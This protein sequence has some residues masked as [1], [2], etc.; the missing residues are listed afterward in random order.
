MII[1]DKCRIGSD[2][3]SIF[4]R[5]VNTLAQ[6]LSVLITSYSSAS[7][8]TLKIFKLVHSSGLSKKSEHLLKDRTHT[9]DLYCSICSCLKN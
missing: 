3:H 9:D 1:Y 4:S 6:I 5:K 8:N 2:L 7:S